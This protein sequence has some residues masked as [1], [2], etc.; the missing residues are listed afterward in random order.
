MESSSSSI[1]IIYPLDAKRRIVG[2]Q[3]D[4]FKS[5]GPLEAVRLAPS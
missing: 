1:I 4:F 3:Q 5:V 2:H